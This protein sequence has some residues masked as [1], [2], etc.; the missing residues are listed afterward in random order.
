MRRLEAAALAPR[1]RRST[2]RVRRARPLC[3]C[4]YE[5]SS[6]CCIPLYLRWLIFG[7]SWLWLVGSSVWK[8]NNGYLSGHFI[9][10]STRFK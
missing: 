6:F 2:K 5:L 3:S 9:I 10:V 8:V 7:Q 4:C 1:S